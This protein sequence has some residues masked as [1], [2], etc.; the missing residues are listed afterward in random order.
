M[1][2]VTLNKRAQ[3]FTS[4]LTIPFWLMPQRQP[5]DGEAVPVLHTTPN[6]ALDCQTVDRTFRIKYRDQQ[7]KRPITEDYRFQSVIV[8]NEERLETLDEKEIRKTK[9]EIAQ[10]LSNTIRRLLASN[11]LKKYI[12]GTERTTINNFI[13]C[14]RVAAIR[15]GDFAATSADDDEI[16]ALTAYFTLREKFVYDELLPG[17]NMLPNGLL[18][19]GD[20]TFLPRVKI[21]AKHFLIDLKGIKKPEDFKNFGNYGKEFDDVGLAKICQSFSQQELFA[22]LFPGFMEGDEPFLPPWKYFTCSWQGNEGKELAKKAIRYVLRKEEAIKAD[23]SIDIDVLKTK[24]WSTI[25]FSEE[26]GLGGMLVTCPFTRN[27]FEAIKLAIPEGIGLEENQLNPWEIRYNKMWQ[28]E[29]S[30]GNLLIEHLVKY[31]VEK[32]LPQKLGVKLLQDNGKLDPKKTKDINWVRL[33]EEVCGSQFSNSPIKVHEVLQKLYPDSFGYKEDQIQP[34][35]FKYQGKWDGETGKELFKKAFLFNLAKAGF[36]KVD[37]TDNQV[38]VVFSKEV[39]EQRLAQGRP[40]FR[41]IINSFGSL[42]SGFRKLFNGTPNDAIAY[43]FDA[44]AELSKTR[45]VAKYLQAIIEHNGGRVEIILEAGELLN[46]IQADKPQL[47]KTIVQEEDFSEDKLDDDLKVYADNDYLENETVYNYGGDPTIDTYLNEIG[48]KPLLTH[49]EAIDLGRK[50][51]AGDEEAKDKLTTSNLRLVVS[52]SK[53]YIGRGLSYADLIQEGNL[54][55]MRA[56]DKFDPEKGFRFS[57]YASWWI[58]K[59]VRQALTDTS[60][61]IRVPKS[62]LAK[63]YKIKEAQAKLSPDENRLT[64]SSDQ[65]A[66]ELDVPK[67]KVIEMNLAAKASCS[68]NSP[69]GFSDDEIRGTSMDVA[70]QP[71]YADDFALSSDLEGV[72]K[73]LSPKERKVIELRFGFDGEGAKT[74]EEVGKILGITREGVRQQEAKALLKLRSPGRIEKLEEYNLLAS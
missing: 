67:E 61:T 37:F 35:E 64:A 66:K 36:G 8:P 49:E 23:G 60:R 58:K 56:V 50:V 62:G 38:K 1:P 68:L 41:R 72:L 30:E 16:I 22:F 27:I 63:I 45:D 13:K 52:I 5:S 70:E 21:L 6:Y 57:T 40:N 25:F 48:K 12:S 54:G 18:T 46:S 28:M 20:G 2:P 4:G 34:W 74:L 24:N 73:T 55:L 69:T 47:E 59:F 15:S 11:E 42:I 17:L 33:C 44:P 53:R 10:H 71:T 39:L 51:Q 3:S 31:I 14:M 19:P 65:V 32:H 29:D 7:R 9:V 43:A 26:Y